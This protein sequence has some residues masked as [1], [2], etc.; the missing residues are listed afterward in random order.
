MKPVMV[1]ILLG[2]LIVFFSIPPAWLVS[3]DRQ[4]HIRNTWAFKARHG[5]VRVQILVE[6]STPNVSTLGILYDNGADPSLA[7]EVSFLR[8]VLHQ[9]PALG[10]DPH[11][12][13]SIT[14]RGFGEPDVRERLALAALHSKE[15]QS[16]ATVNGGAERAVED[17]LNS[18]HAYSA[19]NE[20][21]DE[22]GLVVSEIGGVER[23]ILII[24]YQ[25]GPT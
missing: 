2:I 21:L 7:E 8:E 10:I 11:S 17:L 22:Y 12:V 9:L 1:K 15:W 4:A 16:R 6:P 19:L 23:P 18:Q 13:G 25:L 3:Q 14:V 24:G 20:A 5:T